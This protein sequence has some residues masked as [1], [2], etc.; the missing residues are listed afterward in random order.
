M[1]KVVIVKLFNTSSIEDTGLFFFQACVIQRE[2][3]RDRSLVG[4]EQG[5]C[6]VQTD[7]AQGEGDKYI[8]EE[9]FLC[10]TEKSTFFL[11]YKR[12]SHFS[13]THLRPR[14]CSQ[15]AVTSEYVLCLKNLLA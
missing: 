7:G 11:L 5:L 6:G 8:F 10:S 3:G 9:Y 12:S 14:P 15:D 1:S 2:R 4:P 13:G